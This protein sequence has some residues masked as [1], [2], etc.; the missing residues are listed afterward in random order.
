V[1][2]RWPVILTGII[3]DIL[4]RQ[5]ILRADETLRQPGDRAAAL[6]EGSEII[7]QISRIKSEMS[8]DYAM[9]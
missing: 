7:R 3:N 8:R 4:A 5:E 1:V 6:G 9:P 2:K